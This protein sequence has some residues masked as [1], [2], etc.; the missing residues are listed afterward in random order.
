[1]GDNPVVQS[2]PDPHTAT[3]GTL[4]SVKATDGVPPLTGG[5]IPRDT[6]R[7]KH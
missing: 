2:R 7:G 4:G 1:M 5:G 3:S 6:V